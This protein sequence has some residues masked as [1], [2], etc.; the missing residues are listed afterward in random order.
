VTKQQRS[1]SF[2]YDVVT[3]AVS[4]A[5]MLLLFGCSDTNPAS[6]SICSGDSDCGLGNVCVADRCE[7]GCRSVRDC[8]TSAPLCQADLGDNGT[9]VTCL[10]NA[11]CKRGESCDAGTC[12][13]SCT[14]DSDCSGQRCNTET[15]RC[16]EC[17]VNSQ[18]PLG[19]VCGAD[20]TCSGG[21]LGDRD[22]QAAA[23]HCIGATATTPGAC[24]A[25]T[26]SRDCNS[27]QACVANTCVASCTRNADCPGQICDTGSHTC[28]ECL[29]TSSCAL[30]SV[31]AQNDCVPGCE[32]SRDCPS[33]K[34]ICDVNRGAHGTCFACVVDDDCAQN[35]T[36]E[37]NA[38]VSASLGGQG[39]ACTTSQQCESLLTCAVDFHCRSLCVPIVLPCPGIGD[40]CVDQGAGV[41]A[42]Y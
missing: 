22:C 35:Q 28:V 14:K 25:C 17:L 3:I 26:G 8:P 2:R 5:T 6:S 30:G 40:V 19:K 4:I 42:C 24:V 11:D 1:N 29:T 15:M 23:P 12:V 32:G 38:C 27:N 18:C 13:D 7:P 41:G 33:S 20:N 34:P 9:C 21:C 36:C 39:D 37:G 10:S 31:C 16:V